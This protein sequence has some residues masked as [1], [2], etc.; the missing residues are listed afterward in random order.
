MEIQVKKRN[1]DFENFDANKVNKVLEWACDGVQGVY[2]DDICTSFKVNL[3]NKISTKDIHRGLIDTA[4]GLIRESAPN[5]EQVAANLLNYEL[6]KEVWGGKNSPDFL[7]IIK[8][9]IKEKRYTKEILEFFTEDEI[10]EYGSYIDHER[11]FRFKYSGLAQVIDKYLV[12]N[13]AIKRVYETPNIAYMLISMC[14]FHKEKEY[15]KDGYDCFSLH[16]IS[17]PTPIF[18]GVRTTL[19]SFSSCCLMDMGDDTDE[20]CATFEAVAKATAKRYGIGVNMSKMRPIGSPI[21]NG[22][23][24][25]TGKVAFLRTLQETIKTWMQSSTRSG[26]LTATIPIW[27]YEIE[28]IIQLK[29]IMRLPET[30]VGDIDYSIA[31][32][33]LFYDRWKNNE[34]ITLFNSHEVPELDANYGLPTFDEIY[35]K[36]EAN[37]K[38][39]MKKVVSARELFTLFNKHRIETGRLYVLNV[40]HANTH[41]SFK[42]Q[43]SMSNLC[44]T[45]D[46][47]IQIKV[48]DEYKT[49]EIDGLG[50]YMEKGETVS[51][52]SFD[53][54]KGEKVFSEILDFAQTGESV[55]LVEIEDDD[56]NILR[57]T[58]EHKVFTKNRG[59]VEAQH[60]KSEDIISN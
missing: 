30:R 57:C 13:L 23:S 51:V 56:G 59:Y 8:E 35:R 33:K 36:A 12:K 14:L 58:P 19:K 11:D 22:E 7:S 28:E 17:L 16:K 2:Q 55:E 49:V 47:L 38:I 42:D 6:R 37:P 25:H 50:Y 52:M 54:E 20:I 10:N 1:G 46:T 27:D 32:S 60:L 18:A 4:A 53:E 26:A 24:L 45:G 5:Y 31:F 43:V 34:N 40:D 9:G 48:G 41:G 29:D 15:I 21:R 39:K 3:K 44:V